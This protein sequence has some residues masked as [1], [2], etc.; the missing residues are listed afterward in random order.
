M[1]RK[2][3]EWVGKTD[4]TPVPPRVR[5][6][7]L[8]AFG[9]I[10]AKC[11]RPLRAGE[12]FTCDHAIALINGGA[13]RESNLQPIGDRCCLQPKNAE[14]VAE[15]SLVA[16]KAKSNYGI[17]SRTKARWRMPGNRD[18]KTV[19]CIGGGTK[20][21]LTLAQKHARTMQARAIV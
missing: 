16:R 8:K 11:T 1:A 20:P 19:I 21:R 13:N 9:K 14:D 5:L 12:P 4:D 18:S 7:V 6:R 2:V 17:K 15:K 3:T 10:C